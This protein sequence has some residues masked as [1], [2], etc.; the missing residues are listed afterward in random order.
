MPPQDAL[1][2][3]EM[4][5]HPRK[6]LAWE[7]GIINGMDARADTRGASY[8][9]IRVEVGEYLMIAQSRRFISCGTPPGNGSSSGCSSW[10]C[11]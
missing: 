10:A 11:S 9:W 2:R 1:G 7:W 5:S 3:D 4:E 8:R 6:L